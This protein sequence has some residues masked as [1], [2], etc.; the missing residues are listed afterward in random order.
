[1]RTICL[2]LLCFASFATAYLSGNKFY[3]DLISEYAFAYDVASDVL[4]RY[5]AIPNDGTFQNISIAADVYIPWSNLSSGVFLIPITSYPIVLV[6]NIPALN[7]TA[8]RVDRGILQS[9]ISNQ[10][11]VWNDPS[12]VQL[13]PLLT[14]LTLPVRM[15][16]DSTNSPINQQ[17]MNYVFDDQANQN[18]TWRGLAAPKHVLVPDYASVMAAVG[19]LGNSVAFVPLPYF[20]SATTTPAKL[21]YLVVNGTDVTPFDPLE[22][23]L[24]LRSQ[25]SLGAIPISNWPLFDVTYL[26]FNTT[27]QQ[28]SDTLDVLRFFYWTFNNTHLRNQTVQRGFSMFDAASYEILFQ[29]IQSA[30]CNG[31]TVL[32]YTNLSPKT[33]TGVVFGISVFLMVILMGMVGATWFIRKNKTRPL[34]VINHLLVVLGLVLSLAS[35][36]IWWFSPVNTSYCTSRTWLLGLGYTN[37]IAAIYIY[38]FSLDKILGKDRMSHLMLKARDIVVAY[39]VLEVIEVLILLVWTFVEEPFGGAVITNQIRW[40]SMYTCTTKYGVVDLIQIIYF[41][42][43]SVFGCYVI[44]RHWKRQSPED[45]RWLLVALYN[46][47]L[48]FLLF[49]VITRTQHF[50]DDETFILQVFVFVFAEA[51]VVCSFFLPKFVFRLKK[52]LPSSKVASMGE[53]TESVTNITEMERRNTLTRE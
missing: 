25:K 32:Q 20:K 14:N 2:T 15:I 10:T 48:I 3:Q 7:G 46:Q 37:V 4:V 51:N 18:G 29:H 9:M 22:Y 21:A 28:C 8:L 42:V 17:I 31:V 35:F 47:I 12:I 45:T 41:C 13:N 40:E 36:V 5:D 44:Y 38:V 27:S 30:Q 6:T 33:R 19:V 1:M 16:F 11:L 39:V 43:I 50:T 24:F 52:L 53:R 23:R 34:I 49:M 26:G